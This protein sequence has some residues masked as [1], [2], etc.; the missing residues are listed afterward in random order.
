MRFSFDT[1]HLT[2]DFTILCRFGQVLEQNLVESLAE[3][4]VLPIK[5]T[6]N[7]NVTLITIE[8]EEEK[9]DD[10]QEAISKYSEREC[11]EN[12]PLGGL[13]TLTRLC[14]KECWYFFFY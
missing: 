1:A 14:T 7:M 2:V 3:E 9:Y 12:M 13:Y 5:S 6:N 8:E 11:V 10:A 4:V